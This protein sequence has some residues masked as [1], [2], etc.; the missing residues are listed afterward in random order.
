MMKFVEK[1]TRW[2]DKYKKS[3]DEVI[4]EI[5]KNC[6]IINNSGQWYDCNIDKLFK[7]N[8]EIKLNGKNIQY[9]CIRFN[10]TEKSDNNEDFHKSNRIIIYSIGESINYII[11]KNSRSRTFLRRILGYDKRLEIEK[12][13][14]KIDDDLLLWLIS[15][16]YL[17]NTCIETESNNLSDLYLQSIKYFEGDSNDSQTKVMARGE[18]VMNLLST[19]SFLLE[20]KCLRNIELELKYSIH[21]SLNLLLQ[22]ELISVGTI[23]Y[24]GDLDYDNEDEKFVK[25]T[26]LTYLEI[27]PIINQEYNLEKDSDNWNEEKYNEFLKVIA[28]DINDKI[29]KIK[30]NNIADDKIEKVKIETK[31]D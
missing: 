8:K 29:E 12:N 23:S 22:K 1:T 21:Q 7:T 27:M 17:G 13:M 30:K 14:P 26:L 15:R 25:L 11:D 5:E 20:S 24:N 19:L 10:Y 3:I 28:D 31:E 6:E 18:S 2:H 9:N 4:E 16:I